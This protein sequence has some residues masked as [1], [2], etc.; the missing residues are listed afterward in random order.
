[1]DGCDLEGK[2]VGGMERGT[3]HTFFLCRG[4]PGG[5]DGMYIGL[6]NWKLLLNKIFIMEELMIGKESE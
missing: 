5:Q 6:E 1:M 4:N 2:V 3:G